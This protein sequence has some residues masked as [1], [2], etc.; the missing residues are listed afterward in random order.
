M[1]ASLAEARLTNLNGLFT[2]YGC[3]SSTPGGWVG[4]GGSRPSTRRRKISHIKNII[5]NHSK[6]PSLPLRRSLCVP[7]ANA[8]RKMRCSS[9]AAG[10]SSARHAATRWSEDASQRAWQ[11]GAGCR[12]GTWTS[13]P[14][15]PPATFSTFVVVSNCRL[16]STVGKLI[17]LLS[18]NFCSSPPTGH[19]SSG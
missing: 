1:T 15:T 8:Q 14:H 5:Q 12:S 10:T 17:T 7:S 11:L 13:C 16:V 6:L 18:Y 2:L 3:S 19:H 4:G 9:R